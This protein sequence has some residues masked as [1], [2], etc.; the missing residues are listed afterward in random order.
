[1]QRAQVRYGELTGAK[2][3]LESKLTAAWEQALP[4]AMLSGYRRELYDALTAEE[5]RRS[6]KARNMP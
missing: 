4:I 1:M 3:K 5:R 2:S 6:W